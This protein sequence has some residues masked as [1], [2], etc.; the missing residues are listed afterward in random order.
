M[1]SRDDESLP[2][3]QDLRVLRRSLV[4]PA[5]GRDADF[6]LDQSNRK[7]LGIIVTHDERLAARASR[8]IRLSDGVVVEDSEPGA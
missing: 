7:I 8:V 6:A 3:S 5:D 2:R 1:M 4:V